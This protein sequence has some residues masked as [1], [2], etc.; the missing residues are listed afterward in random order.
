MMPESSYSTSRATLSVRRPAGPTRLLA[1]LPSRPCQTVFPSTQ[2]ISSVPT[3]SNPHAA[4]SAIIGAD[5]SGGIDDDHALLHLCNHQPVDGQ[6]VLKVAAAGA[7]QLRVGRN[8]DRFCR[9]IA[10][11]RAGEPLEGAIDKYKGY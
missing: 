4:C 3:I 1:F 7:S 5:L 8:L 10:H 11:F 2:A 6:L 9:N